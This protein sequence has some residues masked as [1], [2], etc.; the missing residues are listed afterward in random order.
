MKRHTVWLAAALLLFAIAAWLMSLGETGLATDAKQK[1][2][3]FPHHDFESWQREEKRLTLPVPMASAATEGAP[4]PAR[5][6]D[7]ILS[8]MAPNAEV[9]LVFEATAIRDS[10]VGELL[11]RCMNGLHGYAGQD[12][13]ESKRLD[14]V[15]N[16]DRLA[17]SDGVLIA[18]GNFG[19]VH[20]DEILGDKPDM[21]QDGTT[22][23]KLPLRASAEQEFAIHRSGVVMW[24]PRSALDAAIA[25]LDGR[26]PYAPPPIAPQETY[27]EI[28]G[29]VRSARL[30]ELLPSELREKFAD[31][32]SKVELHADTSDDVL[33]V[34]DV[35]GPQ[36]SRVEDLGRAL[37][38]A[39]AVGRVKARVDN[40][41][42][43]EQ[44]ME[45]S[46]VSLHGSSFRIESAFPLALIARGLGSCAAADAGSIGARRDSARER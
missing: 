3:Q 19:K 39:L 9:N 46:R 28:Y 37:A 18:S 42:E 35:E 21:T 23:Y 15:H 34:A 16:L 30:S 1:D 31:A 24:G 27:G 6:R 10:P 33:I 5:N 7:P 14:L 38:G 32:S 43:L 36:A 13:L 45:L 40:D 2:R 26:A 25:R 29:V 22:F 8:A 41:K 44:M 12:T 4:V 20:W 11:L 17:M